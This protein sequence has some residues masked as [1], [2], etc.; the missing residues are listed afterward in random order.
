MTNYTSHINSLNACFNSLVAVSGSVDFMMA[1]TTQMPAIP[2]S[3]STKILSLLSPPIAFT[4]MGTMVCSVTFMEILRL[5][6][7]Q[8]ADV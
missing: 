4:G 1:E 2:E 5:T 8:Y 7:Q 6:P 3:F